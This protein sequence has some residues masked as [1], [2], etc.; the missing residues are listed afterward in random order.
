MPYARLI[1]G[2]LVLTLLVASWSTAAWANPTLHVS[3][4][5][6]HSRQIFVRRDS[7]DGQRHEWRELGWVQ[8]NQRQD[9]TLR[10]GGQYKAKAV[11]RRG[12]TVSR[13][14]FSVGDNETVRWRLEQ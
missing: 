4:H 6:S 5:S 10:H 14:E 13:Y 11:D 12:N 7:S 9:F 3:N 8:G 2:I 1:P